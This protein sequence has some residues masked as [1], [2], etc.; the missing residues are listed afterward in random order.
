MNRASLVRL[1]SCLL[2]LASYSACGGASDDQPVNPANATADS[3][4]VDA[5]G[6]SSPNDTA[7]SDAPADEGASVTVTRDDLLAN[8]TSASGHFVDRY[9][10]A[11][12]FDGGTTPVSNG[13]M[14][15]STVARKN[16]LDGSVSKRPVRELLYPGATTKIFVETQTW[17][18][19]YGV[20]PIANGPEKGQCGSHIDIGYSSNF[21]DH[22]RDQI[23]DM[24]SRG[25]DGALMNWTGRSAGMGVV[26]AMSKT[27]AAITTGTARLFRA[28]AEKRAGKFQFALMEDEGIKSCA[29]DPS[30][31]VTQ[32]VLDDLAFI[33]DQFYDSPAY[34]KT[35]DGRPY[36]FFFS[37]DSYVAPGHA[38]DWSRVRSQAK[39]NPIFIFENAGGWGHAASDGAYS[40]LKVTPIGSYPGDDPFG[41]SGFLPYYYDQASKHPTLHGWG[42]AYKGFDDAVVNG[43]GGGR[44]YA[45]QQ[46]GKTWLD[47]IAYVGKRYSASNQLEALQ[48]PTWDDYEEGSEIETGIDNHLAITPKIEGSTL[49]WSVAAASDAPDD[50][51][52]A[53]SAGFD[54][55]RTVHHYELYAAH[56]DAPDVLTKIGETKAGTRTFDVH[57]APGAWQLTVRAVG[58]SSI[59]NT[60]SA[61]VAFA[62]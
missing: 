23:D 54:I 21:T 7:P 41:L 35:S 55:E 3:G 48:I 38:I 6:D 13:D 24:M 1:V 4:S 17:F 11:A 33:A 49:S 43:W 20:D 8:D 62:P 15:V 59:K 34:L 32:A 50:C 39:G 18:C 51:K 36:L 9:V 19:S 42:S 14:P 2:P 27:S 57:L 12:R 5:A 30:C 58:Q 60:L 45:G 22:V 26:D 28:E 46:C 29:S 10:P 40:W 52:Q 61:S 53:V 31:D 25:I 44:R 16:F 56:A 47:T 37:L